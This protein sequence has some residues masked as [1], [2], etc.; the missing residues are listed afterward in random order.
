[1]IRRTIRRATAVALA[2]GALWAPAASAQTAGPG[3][4]VLV[5]SNPA[6]AFSGYYSEILRAEGLNEFATTSVGALS[7]QTL[8]SYQVV[9][10]APA[11]LNATQV[12]ALTGWV[13]A[14]GNLI[15]MRPGNELAPLL[16]LGGDAGDVSEGYVAIDTTSA[17][18][19]GITAATMQF[20]GAAD[21]RALAAGTHQ[22]AALYTNATTSAGAP[23]VTLRSVGAA[24]GQ[25][26]AFTY[27]LARSVVWTRQGNPAWAG[28]ERDGESG[29]IR[30]DDLFFGGSTAQ[31][32]VNLNKVAIPQADEQQRLL[33]NLVIQMNL[34]RTPLPR[35]WYLPRGENA[36]VVMTGDD[37]AG[38]DTVDHFAAF[39]NASPAGCSVAD[40][41][42]VRATSYVY[43]NTSIPNAESYEADGF[44]LALHLNTGCSD[45]TPSE[46][47]NDWTTQ[48]AAFRASFPTIAAPRTNRTHCIAWSDW[49]GEATAE[50]V[51]NVRFDTNYYYWPGSWV[52]NRPGMFTGSGFPQRFADLNGS[53]IDVYQ[54]TT[55]LVDEWGNDS[56]IPAHTQS[57]IS[58]ANGA[59]GYYGVFTANM[60]TDRPVANANAVVSVAKQNGVPV[61]SA[62]QMLDWIDGRNTSAFRGISYAGGRLHFTVD[63]GNGSRGLQAMLPLRNARGAISSLTRNGAGVGMVQRRVKGVDYA[64][65]SAADGAYVATYGTPAPETTITGSSVKDRTARFAFV[66]DIA[67]SSFQCRMDSGAF[68]ACTSPRQYD[69]L[70]KGA[71]VFQVRAIDPSGLADAT[72]AERQVIV[73]KATIPGGGSGS[74]PGEGGGGPKVTV[75]PKRVRISEEGTATLRVRCPVSELSCRVRLRLQLRGK[76]VASRTFLVMG[77]KRRS[78]ELKLRRSTRASLARKHSVRVTAVAVSR[79]PGGD[80]RVTR[81]K[82]RLVGR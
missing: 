40:W 76:T 58:N 3:G 7:A 25:V 27:D 50:R 37:H 82:I 54:A 43:P 33:A 80:R 41:G 48:L 13:A 23:A 69:N 61:V 6:D 55:Q 66:S 62:A 52:A 45:F 53:M 57:L 63:G 75:S 31:D 73:G 51:H 9:V 67:G 44:E 68:T 79:N 29:P 17:P 39:R 56:W 15:A 35:F 22:V 8:S 74:G 60:H 72:P 28:D 5:V 81:K 16:G 59:A 12:S 42:C 49:V 78:V 77:G 1:M 65:F 10:L 26:A 30:S 21:R 70:S 19:A 71:H 11:A 32:W 14:G 2:V 38:G 34:D 4:P 24:G 20:H 36:A 64:F 47:A 46:I 18:G